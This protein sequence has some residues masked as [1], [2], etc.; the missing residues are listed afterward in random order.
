MKKDPIFKSKNCSVN[1]YFSFF[2]YNF[3]A[4]IFLK[5]KSKYLQVYIQK[6]LIKFSIPHSNTYLPYNLNYD[7]GDKIRIAP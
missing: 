5:S 6:D 2:R 1:P 3:S 7:D 4:K